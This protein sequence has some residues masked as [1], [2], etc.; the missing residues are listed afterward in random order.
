[1][2]YSI[3]YKEYNLTRFNHQNKLLTGESGLAADVT[4]WTLERDNATA[5]RKEQKA[6]YQETHKDYLE[7]FRGFGFRVEGLGVQGLG[8]Q[9]L[10]FRGV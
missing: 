1:M 3:L 8:V 4:K 2:G 5:L 9:G 6:T 7:G 10:G